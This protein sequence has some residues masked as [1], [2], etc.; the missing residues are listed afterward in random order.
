MTTFNFVKIVF[1]NF[2]HLKAAEVVFSAHTQ[3]AWNAI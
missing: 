1:Q 3:Y 2:V